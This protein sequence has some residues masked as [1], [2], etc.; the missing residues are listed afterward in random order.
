MNYIYDLASLDR[1]LALELDPVLR[2]LFDARRE[3]VAAGDTEYLVVEPGDTE[4]DVVRHVGFSPLVNPIDERRFPDP[5]FVPHWDWLA[6]HGGWFELIQCFGS[7][8][9]YV[10]LI[11]DAEGVPPDLLALCRRYAGD[12]L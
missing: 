6:D 8:F 10:L 9:G 11:R 3:V 5:A 7:R 2:S 4:A 12:R 1:A